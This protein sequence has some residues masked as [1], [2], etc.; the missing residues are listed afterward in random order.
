MTN[1]QQ[2]KDLLIANQKALLRTS[3]EI[4]EELMPAMKYLA[5]DIGRLNDFLIQSKEFTK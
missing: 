2:E 4:I 1:K 3:V 5:V